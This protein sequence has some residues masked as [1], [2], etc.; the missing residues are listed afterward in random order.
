MNWKDILK[1]VI[2]QGRVKEIEDINI[3]IDED[4]CLRWLQQLQNIIVDFAKK[5]AGMDKLKQNDVGTGITEAE[6]CEF[7]E[8]I[9]KTLVVN[10]KGD[11]PIPISSSTT[12]EGVNKTGQSI[13]RMGLYVLEEK[14]DPYR[15]IHT[16]KPQMSLHNLRFMASWPRRTFKEL[17]ESSIEIHIGRVDF[18]DYAD[19]DRDLF[20]FLERLY[21]HCSWDFTGTRKFM[22]DYMERVREIPDSPEEARKKFNGRYKGWE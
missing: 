17:S 2:T 7:K 11:L 22:Q 21:R 10:K 6:A 14:G 8:A 1:N 13:V 5:D 9:E 4:D 18:D 20:R 19:A 16:I 3:D 12:I 15:G